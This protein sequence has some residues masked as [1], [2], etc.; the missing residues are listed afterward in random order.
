MT[1]RKENKTLQDIDPKERSLHFLHKEE[2][3]IEEINIP[4][5]KVE[6]KMK[7]K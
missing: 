2:I 7:L 5:V 3:K 1:K 6:I 4:E